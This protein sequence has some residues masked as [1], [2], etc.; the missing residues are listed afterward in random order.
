MWRPGK[1]W[2]SAPRKPARQGVCRA[3]GGQG[4][5]TCVSSSI[6]KE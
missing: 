4:G 1:Q 2:G 5:R 6:N 3:G